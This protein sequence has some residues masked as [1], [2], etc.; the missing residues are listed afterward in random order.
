M[1]LRSVFVLIVIAMLV[2]AC[3]KAL[4][5]TAVDVPEPTQASPANPN[6]GETY[7]VNINPADFVAVVDNPYFPLIPGSTK[8]LEGMTENG[9]EH[10]EIKVLSET[11]EVMGIQ[12]TIRQ[13]TVYIGGEL[14]EDTFDWFAQDKTGN[15]W[16]LGEDVSNYENGQLTDK[17][18][19]WEAGV[20]GALPGIIMYADPAAQLGKTYYQEYYAGEA[21]DAATLVSAGESVT[22]A[23]GS[24]ENVVKTFDFT[25]L[26]SAS[27]EHKYY[28]TG[29]GV[30]K[31]V[32]LTT[33][34]IF[35]LVEFTPAGASA[36]PPITVELLPQP[37]SGFP[38]GFVPNEA[39]RVDIAKPIFSNPTSITN[40]L[41]PITEVDQLIQ[42]GLKDGHPHRTEFTLLPDTK[43]VN[44]NGE[45][46]ETR[47]LQFVA[48]LDGR[49]LE[50]A[51]DFLA[52]ADGGAVWYF[53][54]DVYNYENGVVVDRDGTW[55]AGKDG[56]P[57]MIMP[58]NPQVGNIYR[59][60]NIP[61]D[62]FEEVT[63]KTINQTLEGPRGLIEGV[64][65]VQQ[66]GLDGQTTVKAFAP[67]YGEFLAHTEDAGVAVPTD[68][69]SDPLPAE[70]ETLLTGASSI[71]DAADSADWA[72]HSATLATMT[73]AWEAHQTNVDL[74][75]LFPLLDTQMAR[76]LASLTNAIEQQNPE[77]TRDAAF[78]A[79]V[80]TLD[81]QLP[82]RPR[83]EID[84]VRFDL[85]TRRVITDSAAANPG[86]VTGDVTILEFI[87]QRIGH[88]VD[89]P[90]A[91]AIDTQLADL[92]AASDNEDLKASAETAE[93]LLNILTG[94]EPAR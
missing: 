67:G 13:D 52:Q 82:Y 21:E 10:I 48:Y 74:G 78:D 49:V 4:A 34:V 68:S 93:K 40:P 91:Q 39:A 69:L 31:N 51:L 53:G 28:A 64:M 24:F 87:W 3:G 35:E 84:R 27:L 43:T 38:P 50:H 17:A 60:E 12:A 33:G 56:P 15:V 77:A 63:V 59:V 86:H 8:V 41:L 58:A 14:V 92:R 26:D 75:S 85:W 16:Y 47:I 61:G 81:F 80:A 30:V 20:D 11:R 46:T 9:L 71:F 76:S 42:L 62:V 19:S 1:K 25:T 66:I 94:L 89:A 18:G 44:W 23:A 37:T 73:E 79:A 2:T 88:T 36:E 7:T 29:I 83:V 22:V 5:P 90:T 45:Q 32:N 57:A 54:E 65:F 55:L 6:T 72:A 70:L